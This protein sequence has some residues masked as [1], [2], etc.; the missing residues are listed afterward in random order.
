MMTAPKVSVLTPCYRSER[1]IGATIQSV[2]QQR[3]CD[4]EQVVVDDGSPDSSAAVVSQLLAAEPRLRLIRQE[5]GG[6]AKARNAAFAHAAPNTQYLLFLDADD[7]LEPAMLLEM[8]AYLDTRPDVGMVY[9]VPSFIDEEDA[10]LD[11]DPA[12]AGWF[13]RYAPHGWSARQIPDSDSETPFCSLFS[14]TTVIPSISLIRRSVYEQTP[15]WDENFGHVY[16][17]LDLFLQ[18]ALRSAVHRLNKKLLRYRR[19]EHQST[20]DI[21][22]VHRQEQ[23]LYAKWDALIPTLPPEQRRVAEAAK[24]F[25]ESR[26]IPM[27]GWRGGIS[28]W[29]SGDKAKALRFWAGAGRRYA[30]SLFTPMT[31]EGGA[32]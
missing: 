9:C 2:R 24:R 23:K 5:N 32:T 22:R 26:M 7:C 18:I 4:W 3:F 8:T 15:G 20:S 31:A 30:A 29:R 19:H 13:P 28:S 11:L 16:E 21:D 10:P 1:Y 12:D 17:D 25:R 6:V 27:S 14:L